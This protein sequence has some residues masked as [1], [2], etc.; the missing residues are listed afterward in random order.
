LVAR[1]NDAGVNGDRERDNEARRK[2]SGGGKAK[3]AEGVG[4]IVTVEVT[5]SGKEQVAGGK[6]RHMEGEMR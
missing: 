1:W 6:R 3:V 2:V 5:Q 4:T